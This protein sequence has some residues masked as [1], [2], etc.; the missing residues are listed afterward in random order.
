[1]RCYL[2]PGFLC[3]RYPGRSGTF[4]LLIGHIRAQALHAR[5]GIYHSPDD[6]IQFSFQVQAA[7]QNLPDAFKG[8]YAA[9]GPVHSTVHRDLVALGQEY[10]VN[11][12]LC[13]YITSVKRTVK[14]KRC[15]SARIS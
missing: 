5:V 15:F 7:I 3:K 13:E 12:L 4:D 8:S 6:D 11:L 14:V 10:L 2:R 9:V 1:M